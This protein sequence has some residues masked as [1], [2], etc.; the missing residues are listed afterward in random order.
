MANENGTTTLSREDGVILNGGT[1]KI[2]DMASDLKKEGDRAAV[3]LVAAE[4]DHC[5]KLAIEGML[6]PPAER[7]DWLLGADGPLG[8]FG[9]RVELSH[10]LGLIDADY[11]RA[12][13]LVGEL[14]QRFA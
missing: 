8:G 4:L 12:L 10:R 13:N 5:L 9:A 14:R 3:L 7:E 6:L 1:A 11:V 2:Q